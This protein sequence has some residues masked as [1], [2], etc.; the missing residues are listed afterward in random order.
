M[1]RNNLLWACSAA[2][3]L[4]SSSGNFNARMFLTAFFFDFIVFSR[5]SGGKDHLTYIFAATT[6]LLQKIFC[7]DNIWTPLT[8]FLPRVICLISVILKII[9]LFILQSVLQWGG[10]PTWLHCHCGH[11]WLQ[12]G[13]HQTAAEDPAGIFPV[14][15]PRCPHHQA[16]QLLA[17]AEDQLRQ[18]QVWVRGERKIFKEAFYQN[19]R[20]D[21][22]ICAI[23]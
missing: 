17:E 2:W 8:L 6:N 12:V 11:A 15:H 23:N 19:K 13:Q 22:N 14:L 20:Q 5:C 1:L 7:W 9:C 18:L 21:R 4:V 3:F 10:G 16:R